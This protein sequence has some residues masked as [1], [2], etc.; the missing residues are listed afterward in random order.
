MHAGHTR[1]ALHNE[2]LIKFEC[3]KMNFALVYS[4]PPNRWLLAL[5][6]LLEKTPGRPPIHRLCIIQLLELGMNITFKLIWGRRL[7]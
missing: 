3:L 7:A 5:Q 1:A 6:I 4:I 2:C